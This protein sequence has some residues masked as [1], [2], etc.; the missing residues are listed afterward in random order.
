MTGEEGARRSSGPDRN[1][2]FWCWTAVVGTAIPAWLGGALVWLMLRGTLPESSV[3]VV[4]VLAVGVGFAF[5]AGWRC[6]LAVAQDPSLPESERQ[7]IQSWLRNFGPAGAIQVL[8]FIYF[9]NSRF[10]GH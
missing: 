1:V 5:F 9:P 8:L 4:P 2:R 3:T 6:S 10:A 7:K